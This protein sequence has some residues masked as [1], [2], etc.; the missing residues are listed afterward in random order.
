M[1][2]RGMKAKRFVVAVLALALLLLAGSACAAS[3]PKL[4]SNSEMYGWIED[5]SDIGAETPV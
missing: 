2:Y 5:L 3:K 4:P 1:L